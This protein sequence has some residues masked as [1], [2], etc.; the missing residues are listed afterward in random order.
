VHG[1]LNYAKGMRNNGDAKRPMFFQGNCPKWYAI[2]TFAM[3][4]KLGP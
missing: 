2:A 4:A 1:P 3:E